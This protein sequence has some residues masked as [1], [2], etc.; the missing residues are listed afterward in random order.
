[1]AGF[2]VCSIRNQLHPSRILMVMPGIF[3]DFCLSASDGCQLFGTKGGA[4]DLAVFD[5]FIQ[6]LCG[7]LHL[8]FGAFGRSEPIAVDF[9]IKLDKPLKIRKTPVV[10][11]YLGF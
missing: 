1:M 7:H 5:G 6:I 9:G 10:E 4:A 2:V 3:W 11:R 8:I